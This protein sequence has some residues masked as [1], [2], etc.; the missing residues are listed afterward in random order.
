MVNIA[1]PY[2][3]PYTDREISAICIDDFSG[4]AKLIFPEPLYIFV[5]LNN[6]INMWGWHIAHQHMLLSVCSRRMLKPVLNRRVGCQFASYHGTSTLHYPKDTSLKPPV[7]RRRS[8][9]NNSGVQQ[10]GPA[11]SDRWSPGSR[12]PA[13]A[14][15]QARKKEINPQG[16]DR[17]VSSEL[18]KLISEDFSAEWEQPVR[19]T[20]TKDSKKENYE[21]V[22][23]ISP[24]LFALT[25][26]RRKAHKL[27]VKDG[28]ASHRTSVLKVC[29]EAH[30]RGVHV[31][32]VSKKD[33]DRMSSG[34]VHQ[35]VCLQASRLSYLTE[36]RTSAPPK[37]DSTPPVWLVLDGIQDPMNLG[38]VLRSAYFLGVDRVASSLRN[39]CPLSPVVSKASAGVMEIIGVYGYE[40]LADMLKLKVTQGW[41]VV[42]TVGA[43]AEESQ[44]PIIQCSDF[45]MTKP[46]LLLMGG[47]GGGLSREL[48]SQ[49]HTLLT[50]PAHRDLLPGIESLNVSVATGILIHSLLST[51][52]SGS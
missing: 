44:V 43:E 1:F 41:Q 34:G 19:G 23:G 20:L 9:L 2:S 4:T 46:T 24:C 14:P 13:P 28:E 18:R 8:I 7:R 40:S 16:D 6:I 42:G 49:C 25:Q 12:D 35:G 32:R 5:F 47:E 45:H 11:V 50:I 37:K 52:R 27:L 15:S 38:A 10:H 3:P 29:E 36:E 21:I 51:R 48:L 30:R 39:S 31:H 33:L 22:F 17:K 26:G